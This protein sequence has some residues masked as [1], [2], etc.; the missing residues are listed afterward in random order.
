MSSLLYYS[1]SSD[2]TKDEIILI[3]K[4]VKK[5]KEEVYLFVKVMFAFQLSQPL[6]PYIAAVIMPLPPQISIEHLVPGEDLRSNNQCPD[7][8]FISKT[9]MDK[10]ICL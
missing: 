4:Q 7:I 2:L 8:A 3:N 10:R 5:N 1:V 6:V 9:K